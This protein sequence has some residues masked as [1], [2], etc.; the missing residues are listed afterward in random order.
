MS[1]L[2]GIDPRFLHRMLAFLPFFSPHSIHH[3]IRTTARVTVALPTH[4][5]CFSVPLYTRSFLSFFIGYCGFFLGVRCV[6]CTASLA[7]RTFLFSSRQ[8][9][10]AFSCNISFRSTHVGGNKARN[11]L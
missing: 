11:T 6:Y 10:V 3:R 2:C 7:A 9:H 5:T 8:S 1:R 4:L